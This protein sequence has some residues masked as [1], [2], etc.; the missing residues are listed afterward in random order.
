[1]LLLDTCALIWLSSDQKKLSKHARVTIEENGG[2]IF[3]SAIS[4]FEIAIAVKKKRLILPISIEKWFPEILSHH[5]IEEIHLENRILILSVKLPEHH[6]D[7][8][9]RIIVA[10][11]I[12][13]KLLIITPDTLIQKYEDIRICW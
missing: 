12:I 1:M 13:R 10:T 6:N 3:V 11:S 8:A 5:G 9:D 4:S 2:K 7:P